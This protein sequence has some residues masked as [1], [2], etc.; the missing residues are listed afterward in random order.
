MVGGGRSA[1]S[2]PSYQ[3]GLL[4]GSEVASMPRL[5]GLSGSEPVALLGDERLCGWYERALRARAVETR[6]FDGE[7]AAIAGLFALYRMGAD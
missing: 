4:I 7:A 5:L 3:S 2:R 1:E 6:S